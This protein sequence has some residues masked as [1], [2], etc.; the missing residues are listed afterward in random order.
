MCL[1]EQRTEE[2]QR[3][4]DLDDGKALRQKIEA[5]ER[6]IEQQAHIVR[7]LKQELEQKRTVE[8]ELR[9]ELSQSLPTGKH[10]GKPIIKSLGVTQVPCCAPGPVSL[11]DIW[12]VFVRP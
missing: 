5:L 4:S 2:S 6:Q 9:T 1:Q 7:E 12:F 8:R 10:E 11:A 3:R